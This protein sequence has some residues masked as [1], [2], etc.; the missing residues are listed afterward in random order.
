MQGGSSSLLMVSPSL[1]HAAELC[2]CKAM[3]AA[4]KRGWG[5]GCWNP[6]AAQ[7]H[8]HM[9]VQGWHHPQNGKVSMLSLSVAWSVA[10]QTVSATGASTCIKCS[11]HP[12]LLDHT[13]A[14]SGLKALAP[15]LHVLGQERSYPWDLRAAV[16]FSGR[17]LQKVEQVCRLFVLPDNRLHMPPSPRHLL[18][19]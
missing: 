11:G 1:C 14:G 4:G 8:V 17:V 18:Q 13:I 12:A 19:I 10:G 9:Q 16:G 15:L 5:S 7:R 6:E 3:V 2:P